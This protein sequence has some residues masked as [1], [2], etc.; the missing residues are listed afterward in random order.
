M[1]RGQPSV[2]SEEKVPVEE[3]SMMVLETSAGDGFARVF[4]PALGGASVETET[5]E[6]LGRWGEEEEGR[7]EIR[8]GGIW[9][10]EERI[11]FFGREKEG[12]GKGMAGESRA[13][14]SSGMLP[15]E[16]GGQRGLG[17]R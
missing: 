11:G 2:D 3:S 16:R 10:G 15:R 6:H 14:G 17:R 12:R 7:E 4:S 9:W 8:R 13:W 5:R 1:A